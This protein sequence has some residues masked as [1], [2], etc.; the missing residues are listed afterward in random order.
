MPEQPPTPSV[1]QSGPDPMLKPRRRTG[2]IAAVVGGVVVA[3]LL[4]GYF[5]A[6]PAMQVADYKK[7]AES[8][9]QLVEQ[10]LIRVF[11]SFK[12][13][14]FTNSESTVQADKADLEVAADAIKDARAALNANEAALT[15]FSAWPLLDW[16]SAYNKAAD[17]QVLEK[18]YVQQARQ[19]LID[20]EILVNYSTASLTAGADVETA[21]T[22][23]ETKAAA[24]TTA[25][26][27]STHLDVFI[28]AVQTYVTKQS[29]L[30]PPSYLKDYNS[31]QIVDA[32][33]MIATLKALSASVKA[34]DLA[35]IESQSAELDKLTTAS[36]A[37]AKELITTL[38]SKSPISKE[39]TGLKDL[40]SKI[41]YAF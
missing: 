41:S 22:T 2:L 19:F 8:K 18:A 10:K 14:A 32:N 34:E 29:A 5:V 9:H 23:F 21:T 7:A 26:E 38:Q 4:A 35:K 1:P 3:A 17:T 36:A 11:D 24:A 37:D 39:I 16:N 25:K 13:G 20:Y 6:V 33:K 12:R 28:A 15:K 40:A 30:T 27:L 31:K